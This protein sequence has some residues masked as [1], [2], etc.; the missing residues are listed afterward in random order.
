MANNAKT[1]AQTEAALNNVQDTAVP[2]NTVT[3][4]GIKPVEDKAPEITS[5]A[6]EDKFEKGLAES[7]APVLGE[8]EVLKGEPEKPIDPDVEAKSKT[9]DIEITQ[10]HL[11]DNPG[12]EEHV[13]VGDTIT[14]DK[15]ATFDDLLYTEIEATK[16]AY[17]H[18]TVTTK[19]EDG[20]LIVF[21]IHNSTPERVYPETR[22]LDTLRRS[23]EK[24]YRM[25]PHTCITGT[26]EEV[27][28]ALQTLED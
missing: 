4:T 24:V 21:I 10:E 23:E 2:A 5:P 16:Q 19:T 12:L 25:G 6:K 14:V 18:H 9:L 8:G 3:D 11:N 17:P 27:L 22:I 7:T 1:T 26:P 20:K 28:E 13:K 15:E